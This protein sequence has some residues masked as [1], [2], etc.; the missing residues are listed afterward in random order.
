MG[1]SMCSGVLVCSN[2]GLPGWASG[3]FDNLKE[4]SILGDGSRE[5][6]GLGEMLLGAE[7]WPGFSISLGLG[8][9]GSVKGDGL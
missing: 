5:A 4:K 9:V 2:F 8:E 6:E 7:L 1:H 3:G